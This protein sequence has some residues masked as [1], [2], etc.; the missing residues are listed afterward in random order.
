MTL[1]LNRADRSKLFFSFGVGFNRAFYGTFYFVKGPIKA[2]H[3]TL[4]F[5]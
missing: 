5:D 4:R 3:N 2:E 1:F